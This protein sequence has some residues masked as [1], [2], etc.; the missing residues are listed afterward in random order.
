MT[1]SL[2]IPLFKITFNLNFSLNIIICIYF[3]VAK[4]H[5]L[6]YQLVKVKKNHDFLPA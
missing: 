4:F 1:M 3:S 5:N 2:D 6:L